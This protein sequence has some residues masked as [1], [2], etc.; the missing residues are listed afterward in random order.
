M[1]LR[2]RGVCHVSHNACIIGC[3]EQD[4]GGNWWSQ[5]VYTLLLMLLMIDHKNE[6]PP[7]VPARPVTPTL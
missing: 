6:G 2:H 4:K 1:L 3:P 7:A 5:S